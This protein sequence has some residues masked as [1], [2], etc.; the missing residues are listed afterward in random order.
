MLNLAGCVRIT[1]VGL[2]RFPGRSPL[3]LRGSC[4]ARDG[5][6]GTDGRFSGECSARVHLG[7]KSVRARGDRDL[8]D[9]AYMEAHATG[10]VSEAKAGLI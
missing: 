10:R 1:S 7:R 2:P 9:H 8:P 5:M 4:S 6:A 3:S